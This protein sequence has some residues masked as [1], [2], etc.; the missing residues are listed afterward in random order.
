MKAFIVGPGLEKL[1]GFKKKLVFTRNG[2]VE[3]FLGSI[4]GNEIII[5]PRRKGLNDYLPHHIN[6]LA[7]MRA[8]KKL[9]ATSILSLS[10]A[11]VFDPRVNLASP[12]IPSDIFFPENRLP[13]GASCT[14][15]QARGEDGGHLIFDS[16]FNSEIQKD[17]QAIFPEALTD[18]VYVHANGPRFNTKVEAEFFKNLGGSV[19][20][21]TCGPEA[22]LAN[23]L[24]IPY[25]QVLFTIDY[26][27]GVETESIE[28]K[29]LKANIEKSK[30]V[31]LKTIKEF[32]AL[33]KDY[34]FENT[35]HRAG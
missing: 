2:V 17:L 26:V 35:I 22:V 11:G 13:N 14:I 3:V 29:E 23:E 6:F 28:A 31:F 24:E 10:T 30:E 34:Q 20:S 32:S 7:N 12:I 8:L 25:G 27:N 18:T 16:L 33:D 1:E 4:D 9:G 15:F 5:L 21:Q 19:I